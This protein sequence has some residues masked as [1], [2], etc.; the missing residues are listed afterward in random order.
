M[1][2]S[3][4]KDHTLWVEKWR[5]TDIENYVGNDD[6]ISKVK[7]YI[8]HGDIPH[9]LLY[10]AAG[11]GKCLDFSEEIDIEIELSDI[12]QKKLAKYIQK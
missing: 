6:I 2:G 1:F 12:E 4:E 8:Q 7:L 3:E 10:G 11:T 5:P 9:L